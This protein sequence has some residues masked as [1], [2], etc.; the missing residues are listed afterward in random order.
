MSDKPQ[1]SAE[2]I[3]LDAGEEIRRSVMEIDVEKD[4]QQLPEQRYGGNY[5][6][7]RIPF[8]DLLKF[9]GQNLYHKR[10][11]NLKAVMVAGLGW[12]LVTED[13]DK[14]EDQD[15]RRI[16]Q[17][18]D[19][20]NPHPSETFTEICYRS[21]ID[22]QAVGNLF[23]EVP[24]NLKQEP[25]EIYHARAKTMRRDKS[26][27]RGYWQLQKAKTQEFRAWGQQATNPIKNEILHFYAYDPEQSHYGIAEWYPSLA[28]MILDRSV[29]EYNI[30]LFLN[31]LM[32]K[33]IIVVEG[34]Q[35]SPT[36][37]TSLK[38]YLS[39]NFHGIK[40][41][42]RTIILSSDDPN[43]KIRIE[44]LEISFGEK[45][46][47]KSGTRSISRDN[48]I[49]AH[50]IPPRLMSIINAGQLGGGNENE[51]QLTVFKSTIIDP[52]QSRFEEFLNNTLIK[53]FGD[54]KWKLKFNEFDVTNL[55][56]LANALSKLTNNQAILDVD[57]AREYMNKA[58][59]ETE[60][61]HQ[62]TDSVISLRKRLEAEL[63]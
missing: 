12:E 43:V 62:L 16:K 14:S 9:Y 10:A 52:E 38:D 40:N 37:K 18:L 50:G 57:E 28:E 55:E 32:A 2:I 3:E 27:K 19:N 53:A 56:S 4:S 49:A 17:L 51:G 33:F 25:V 5:T 34:G 13:E 30:N 61:L 20:P 41:A 21:Q 36:A 42:G 45:S 31:Q 11:C 60:D 8:K 7:P 54:H 47:P 22:Y 24:R 59:R 15:Y 63:D 35:L 44:K 23:M 46:D 58:P 39:K 26:L 48:V 29:V 1:V 6:E